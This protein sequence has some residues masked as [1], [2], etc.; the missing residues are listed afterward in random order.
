MN[1]SILI[2]VK[3]TL[4][5]P[6]EFN[7]FDTDIIM[8]TN[9]VLSTLTQ[10]GVGPVEGFSISSDSETWDELLGDSKNLEMVKAYITLQVRKD[11]DPPQNASILNAIQSR[12]DELTW[13]ISVAVDPSKQ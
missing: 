1:D 6:A 2:S 9:S 5:I 13:R 10:L 7:E 12:L 8:F 3:K 11:F 4:G